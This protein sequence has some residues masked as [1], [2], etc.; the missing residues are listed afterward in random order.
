MASLYFRERSSEKEIL[1]DF[2]LKDNGLSQNLK[3]LERVNTLLGGY[4]PVLAMLEGIKPELQ[5]R[6]LVR[7]TDVGCGGGD[8]L[9]RVH[10]WCQKNRI[11]ARLP[12]LDGNPHVVELARDFSHTYSGIDWQVVNVFSPEFG[13]QTADVLMFNL[14]LHHFQEEE[15]V[16]L[17]KKCRRGCRF[18]II[19]DLQR[20]RLAYQLFRLASRIFRFSYISRHD[21]K[22]SIRKS[23]TKGDW[24]RMLQEAG[25][26]RYRIKW[27]W[28][29]R[30]SVLITFS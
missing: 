16:A 3:E 23:F 21:G 29:F 1:D 7:I 2:N 9:R 13:D 28:A 22:L 19:N 14:F 24:V 5:K 8:V 6:P 4:A 17:L 20:S 12:G 15:I 27:Q 18:L 11:N 26:S 25:I 30:Y 10:H